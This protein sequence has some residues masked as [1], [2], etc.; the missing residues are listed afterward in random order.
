MDKLTELFNAF[1]ASNP[2]ATAYQAFAAGLTA[3]AVSMRER[4]VKVAQTA[5]GKNDIIN[6]IGSLS[7]IPTS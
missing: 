7:D 1:T 2:D 6:G 5:K 3:G 4:A